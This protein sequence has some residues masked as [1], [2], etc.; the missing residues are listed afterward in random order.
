MK[1]KAKP[2]KW[3]DWQMEAF[4]RYR[5]SAKADFLCAVSGGGGKTLFALELA[6][7]R[8]ANDEI[9]R[10]IVVTFTR[11]LIRQWD[12]WATVLGLSLLAVAGNQKLK[13]GLP[14]DCIGYIC[15]YAALGR[16][17]DLHAAFATECRTLIIFDEIHHLGDEDEKGKS[18]WGEKAKLAFS[19][20]SFRLAL[21][22]TPFRSNSQ[23]IP[24]VIYKPVDGSNSISEVVTDYS[25]SY[26]KAVADRVCRRVVF[27]DVDGPIEWKRDD[28]PGV[29]FQHR[30]ADK[31]DEKYHGDR[32]RFAVSAEMDGSSIKNQLLADMLKR[33]NNQL[34]DI[35]KAGHGEAAGLIVASGVTEAKL[36]KAL[37]QDVTGHRAIIVHNE[38]ERSLKLIQD[39]AEGITPWIIS[40]KMITEGVD[41]PRLRVCVYAARI[42][43][44]LFFMQVL[45]RIVRRTEGSHGESYLF[46]PA[47]P[48]LVAIVAKVEDEM[49]VRIEEREVKERD[50]VEPPKHVEKSFIGADSERWGATIAGKNYTDEDLQMADAFRH[51]QPELANLD[52]VSLVKFYRDFRRYDEGR[53]EGFSDNTATES[54]NECRDR[55]RRE[56]QDAVGRLH[57]RLRKPHNEIHTQLN[58]TVGVLDKDS[59]TTEQL[60][61]MLHIANEL[62]AGAENG[63]ENDYNEN[64]G[65]LNA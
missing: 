46:Y 49:R 13:A 55:L 58:N 7:I 24:F 14:P 51:Q 60:E 39:F 27:R 26:G 20:A 57:H 43:A 48:N 52:I 6:R 4:E 3:F 23:K 8:L 47:D 16:M 21:S 37:L 34:N 38:E 11:H 59:A 40:V 2:S 61:K 63:V 45:F 42:T 64:D 54:Y 41:I 29:V 9:D 65:G 15:T 44:E 53:V 35:R 31:I 56:I 30:F 12:E 10:V 36:I 33:A 25:Y 18:Q 5:R 28:Q 32:L 19:K 50:F 1:K 22:G 62:E 17:A